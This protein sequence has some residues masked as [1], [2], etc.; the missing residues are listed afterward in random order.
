MK[1]ALKVI[2]RIFIAIVVIV[3]ACF[4]YLVIFER[5]SE[6]T[7]KGKPIEK[8][9][10]VKSALLVI[11][12]QEAIT[13]RVSADECYIKYSDTLINKIN[14]LI[15]KSGENKIPVIYIRNELTNWFINLL[16][17]SY[18]KGGKG[19]GL[20]KRLRIISSDI[21]TKEKQDAFTNPLL[22]S[23]LVRNRINKL[24][25]V[26]IDA[27]YCVKST[28]LGAKNRGYYVAAITD[29]ILS[30]SDSLK[31]RMFSEYEKNNVKL[32][33]SLDFLSG[34]K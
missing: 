10:S 18:A 23:I 14:R 3:V 22:D 27:A 28:I 6:V 30:K 4:I 7:S 24:Y 12:I 20:D 33:T 21:V 32:M 5:N 25:V 8:Y 15:K 19:A 34:I 11:D 1:T 13:G 9:D 31:N 29:A 17:D 26:G 16:N 2:L